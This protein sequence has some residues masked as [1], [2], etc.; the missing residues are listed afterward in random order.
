MREK[1]GFEGNDMKD[2]PYNYLPTHSG[3]VKLN[4]VNVKYIIVVGHLCISQLLVSVNECDF[5]FL[6]FDLG[7]EI[8]WLFVIE[9]RFS[10]ILLKWDRIRFWIPTSSASV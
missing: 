3:C 2:I 5:C 9:I 4:K 7:I 10:G 1:E 8:S 6:A